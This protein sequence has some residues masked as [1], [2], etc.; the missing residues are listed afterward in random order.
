M[1]RSRSRRREGPFIF[2]RDVDLQELTFIVAVD[3]SLLLILLCTAFHRVLDR[4]MIEQPIPLHDMEGLGERRSEQ[5]AK[6][7][8]A[9][10]PTVSI[11]N[12]SP[13]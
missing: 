13:S 11:T 10:M 2:D 7:P 4:F 5:I 12:V 6:G 9:L 8:S 3:R 1:S